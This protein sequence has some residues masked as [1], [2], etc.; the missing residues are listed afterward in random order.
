MQA[1]TGHREGCA[2]LAT[3]AG[4]ASGCSC[5]VRE[6]CGYVQRS[7]AIS[8]GI[9]TAAVGCVGPDLRSVASGLHPP[10]EV[11]ECTRVVHC[12]V[13]GIPSSCLMKGEKLW[14]T[15]LNPQVTAS[16]AMSR[17]CMIVQSAAEAMRCPTAHRASIAASMS[18]SFT[19]TRS[20]SKVDTTNTPMSTAA[21]GT[22]IELRIPTWSKSRGPTTAKARHPPSTRAPGG[23]SPS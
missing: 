9:P 15:Y 7:W 19:S 1:P 17:I 10:S 3:R 12:L 13:V 2:G 14:I 23:S 18:L 6:W 22:V 4:C 16:G 21:R 5:P 8:F 11:I 20:V